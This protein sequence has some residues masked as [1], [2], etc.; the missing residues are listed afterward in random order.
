MATRRKPIAEVTLNRPGAWTNKGRK[1]IAAWLRAR[2]NWL[3]KHGDLGNPD[4]P[5][6]LRRYA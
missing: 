1:Q 3:E 4:G 6:R 2:A 5:M